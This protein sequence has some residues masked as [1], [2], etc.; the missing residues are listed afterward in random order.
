MQN[1]SETENIRCEYN[2]ASVLYH[3]A[4]ECIGIARPKTADKL[5]WKVNRH[6]T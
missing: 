1:F 4:N 3:V 5:N 2:K 6:D